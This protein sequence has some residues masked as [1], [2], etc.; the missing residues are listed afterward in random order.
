MPNFDKTGPMGKGPRTGRRMGLCN[1]T[2]INSKEYPTCV[3]LKIRSGGRGRGLGRGRGQGPI[4][5]FKAS[6]WATPMKGVKH[7]AGDRDGDGVY[8]MFD[9][10]P[11][12]SKKQGPEHELYKCS[13]CG[14][15][16]KKK[17]TCPICSKAG[18]AYSQ[19]AMTLGS[20]KKFKEEW[21][22]DED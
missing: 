3:G 5:R 2:T 21:N 9:C 4:G 19:G 12:N 15:M 8:N 11:N 22:P 7:F 1:K 6:V 13:E 14:R 16:S 18:Y 20:Y 17:G 10:E